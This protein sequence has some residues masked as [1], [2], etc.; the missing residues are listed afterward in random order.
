M[1][2]CKVG[3][4]PEPRTITYE[5]VA[6]YPHDRKAFTQGLIVAPPYLFES[7]GGYGTSSLR[8]V[9]IESGSIKRIKDMPEQFFG[10]GLALLD[11]RLFQ[12]E[13]KSGVGRIY[14]F[15][16]LRKTGEF[17]YEGEG[18]GLTTDGKHLIMSDGTS[19][20]RFL[21]PTDFSVVRTLTVVDQS[22]YVEDLNELEFVSGSI[23]ANIWHSDL[24]V[25]IDPQTGHVDGKI[26]IAGLERPRPSDREAVPNGIAYDPG[27]QLLYVTGKR[28]TRVYALRLKG[29]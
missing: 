16:T 10:E 18:W 1:V 26:N 9:E 28:W 7:T 22:G 23:F 2:A 8:K 29:E 13:W 27:T 3:R 21:D 6:D 12:L 24:I 19:R 4:A 20:L 15:E 11:G 25:R 14:D 17:Q 5:V